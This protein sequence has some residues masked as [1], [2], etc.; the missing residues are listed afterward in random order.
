M[1][2]AVINETSAADK[3]ADVMAALDGRGHDIINVGMTKSG[4]TPELTY[5]H[6]GLLSALVLNLGKADLVIGGCGSG[7]G[8]LNSALQY[9]NVAC[10]LIQTPL[11][12]WLFGQINGGNC[13]SLALLVGYGW[14]GD[15]NLKFIFDRLFS[16][17]EFGKGYPPHREESQQASRRMLEGISTGTHKSMADIVLALE[18]AVIHPVLN[19]PGVWELLDVES[20]QDAALRAALE[21]RK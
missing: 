8:Y 5:I 21:S 2:I 14:A 7:Q 16:L 11:D 3:N 9:P 10:G 20:I 13:I 15:I 18:D 17:P 1:K 4:D 19:Y 6:T 12:A